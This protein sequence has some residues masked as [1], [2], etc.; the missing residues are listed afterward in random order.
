MASDLLAVAS[1]LRLPFIA[2][3]IY[4]ISL[5]TSSVGHTNSTKEVNREAEVKKKTEVNRET[6]ITQDPA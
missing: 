2:A 1:N 6:P 3:N 4:Y 5:R